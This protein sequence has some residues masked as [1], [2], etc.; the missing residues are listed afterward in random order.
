MYRF[1]RTATAKTATDMPRAVEFGVK[2]S[3]YLKEKYDLP[4]EFSAQLFG[5]SNVY[6]TYTIDSMD[7]MHEL[8]G[9]LMMDA[10]YLGILNEYDEIWVPGSLEDTVTTVIGG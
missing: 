6:W 5:G 9:K 2:V 1:T 8:T 7:K 10:E 3:A 4:L